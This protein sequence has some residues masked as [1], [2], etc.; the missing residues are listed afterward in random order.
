MCTKYSRMLRTFLDKV[1][2][3]FRNLGQSPPDRAMK[4]AATNAFV[5]QT[6]FD[7]DCCRPSM[8]PAGTKDSTRWTPLLS[9]GTHT[10]AWIQPV[11]TS[12]SRSSTRRKYAARKCPIWSRSTLAP[13]YPS[14]SHPPP[15]PRQ[16]I[17]VSEFQTHG[18]TLRGPGRAAYA[19]AGRAHQPRRAAGCTR[20]NPGSRGELG[21]PTCTRRVGS[22]EVD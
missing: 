18:G 1:Y 21:V 6:R 10:A 19:A 9:P 13:N 15:L 8:S 20:R 11:G 7:R 2:Y 12:S 22:A 16:L 17:L 14:A 5:S 4:Y 3:Q